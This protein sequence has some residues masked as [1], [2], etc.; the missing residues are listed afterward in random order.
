M[1]PP[2]T[3]GPRK[4]LHLG[5]AMIDIICIVAAENIERMTFSNEG[6]S[7]LMVETGRKVVAESITTH[8]GGGAC[9]TAVGLA[10]RGWR[11]GVLA[12]TGDDLNAEA[13]R[14]HLEENGVGFDRLITAEGLAT[15][16]AV[17]VAS[18]DRNASIFVHRGANETLAPC[19]LP[20]EV[21]AGLDLVYV[22]PLSS[23]S[24]D[25]LPDVVAKAKAAGA[26][27]AVNPG[28]RQLTSRT[29]DILEALAHVDLLSVNRVEAEALVPALAARGVEKAG[30]VPDDAPALMKRGLSFGGFEMGLAAFMNAVRALGPRWVLVTDGTDGAY[31]AAPEGLFWRPALPV[32]VL[33]TAGA[34]DSYTSTLT[35]AL[36]EGAAPDEAM[37]QAA[38][39]SAAVVGVLDTTSGLMT[40][41]AMAARRAE[42]G[43]VALRVF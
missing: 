20:D 25:C 7:F 21:F 5:S 8:V 16:T 14:E 43:E 40:P 19:D 38:M 13:V 6:K 15:G 39:N 31:L 18:H 37:L 22:A 30:Q 4:S 2:D 3:S 11:A 36:A 17:M 23:D 35:A 42:L 29:G 27:V 9:N 33:G 34:G 12:K 28:I 26:L 1:T 10:R 24:A 32:T 41:D